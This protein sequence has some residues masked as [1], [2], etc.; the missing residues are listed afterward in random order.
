MSKHEVL[1]DAQFG[2]FDP[3]KRTLHYIEEYRKR[4]GLE[5][6]Q[7]RI[8]EWGCGRGRE[9]LWFRERGYDSY[10]VD[11]DPE[12]VR[13]GSRLF[14]SRGVDPGALRVLG[15]DGRADFPDGF[16]HFTYSN[17]V[18]EH[19]SDLT[20]A[21]RELWRVTAANG[22]G[23]HVFPAHR[24]IVE[25]HLFMPFVHWLPKNELRRRAISLYVHAGR[26]PHWRE[27]E[28]KSHRDRAATYYAYS[29]NKTFYR[30]PRQ[31]RAIFESA[32]FAVSYETINHPRV[33]KHPVLGPM[34]RVRPLR[35]LVD[36]MLLTFVSNELHL[37]KN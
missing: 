26:E 35:R 5:P 37:A 29:V 30:S 27:L 2:S 19:V 11:I 31:I 9:T 7:L 18:F 24:Y 33:A 6:S 36:S 13:N 32:N 28:G 21:A 34:T 1:T 23:H 4:A 17:Q 8:L 12:T 15:A 20:R 22:E 25:G 16:F 3:P 14:Q 10:G